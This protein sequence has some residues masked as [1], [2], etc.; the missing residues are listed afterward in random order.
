MDEHG[1]YAVSEFCTGIIDEK[2]NLKK[3]MGALDSEKFKTII[4]AISVSKA[5]INR[6]VLK[7]FKKDFYKYFLE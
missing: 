4:K 2:K 1:A 3:I 6:K 5:E 7:C